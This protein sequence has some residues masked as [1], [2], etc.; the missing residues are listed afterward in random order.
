MAVYSSTGRGKLDFWRAD[1]WYGAKCLPMVWCWFSLLAALE[2]AAGGTVSCGTAALDNFI[3]WWIW[4][5]LAT[6]QKHW[7]AR[8]ESERK[9]AL[10]EAV[11]QLF[12]DQ[13]NT[14]A[15]LHS[16]YIKIGLYTHTYIYICLK[17]FMIELLTQLNVQ[18]L[19][20]VSRLL[21]NYVKMYL[22]NCLLWQNAQ[23]IVAMM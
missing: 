19:W 7:L 14:H 20:T 9:V 21:L 22:V 12:W 13:R 4:S 16:K 17:C 10:P 1:P 23:L 2:S 18:L 5:R 15:L 6:F 11:K 3:G 8:D